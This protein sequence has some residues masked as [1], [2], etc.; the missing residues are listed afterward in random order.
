MRGRKV[1]IEQHKRSPSLQLTFHH[2]H[3][4]YHIIQSI[5]LRGKREKGSSVNIEEDEEKRKYIQEGTAKLFLPSDNIKTPFYNPTM[6]TNR[7]LS[8]VAIQTY[9]SHFYTQGKGNKEEKEIKVLDG[10]TATGIRT[11][12]MYNELSPP[13]SFSLSFTANDYSSSS[14]AST[15]HNFL[16]NKIPFLF[17]PSFPPS[18][19]SPP[20]L[21]LPPS[22]T[23]PS[24]PLSPLSPKVTLSH[25]DLV[26]FL[27]PPPSLL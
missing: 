23:L 24:P 6:T 12:R 10:L 1:T 19:P 25:D 20:S 18:P 2:H 7:D 9:L 14:I 27:F 8:I 3:H 26:Y 16:L 17:S 4:H 5:V 21:F 11:M 13:S 22:L 15:Q